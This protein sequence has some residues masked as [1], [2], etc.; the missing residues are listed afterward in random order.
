MVASING[1]PR[2][3][4]RL[5]GMLT[6]LMLRHY[7]FISV[8]SEEEASS[9]GRMI[10]TMTMIAVSLP[11]AISLN[12]A[13]YEI[14]KLYSSMILFDLLLLAGP[15]GVSV[16]LEKKGLNDDS[17][18]RSADIATLVGLLILGIVRHHRW[19]AILA[20]VHLSIP[21]STQASIELHSLCGTFGTYSVWRFIARR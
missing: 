12:E 5:R 16:M 3:T 1:G 19:I 7:L 11:M 21:E 9:T 14:G 18:N 17:L 2:E 10:A 8:V 15:L 4:R 13:R 6:H 20:N